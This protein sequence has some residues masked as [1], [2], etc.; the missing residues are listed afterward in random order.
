MTMIY[1]TAFPPQSSAS[2]LP[3]LTTVLNAEADNVWVSEMSLSSPSSGAHRL[4]PRWQE[5][6]TWL[7]RRSGTLAEGCPGSNEAPSSQ[8]VILHAGREWLELTDLLEQLIPC[9][10]KA[11]PSTNHNP[12]LLQEGGRDADVLLH[13][14]G[15]HHGLT[16]DFKPRRGIPFPDRLGNLSFCCQLK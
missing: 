3:R 10:C 7:E 8:G 2:S 5:R 11:Q 4:A 13:E 16:Q 15:T 1:L 14:S 9:H 6:R 12:N